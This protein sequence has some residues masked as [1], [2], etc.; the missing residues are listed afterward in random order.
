MTDLVLTIM[1]T[2]K[3]IEGHEK[4]EIFSFLEQGGSKVTC[5]TQKDL[6]LVYQ[7]TTILAM[8]HTELQCR[9]K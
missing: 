6:V 5:N 9:M 4:Y 1:M 3:Q 2:V 8:L 7:Y